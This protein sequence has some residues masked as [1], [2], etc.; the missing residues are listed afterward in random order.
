LAEHR[1]HHVRQ[2]SFAQPEVYETR[3]G[4]LGTCSTS[5]GEVHLGHDIFG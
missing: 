1:L 4:D 2:N 5:S 3:S